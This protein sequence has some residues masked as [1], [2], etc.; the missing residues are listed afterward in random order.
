M[1]QLKE[2]KLK[3]YM[4]Y[5]RLAGSTEGACLVFAN[6]R[7]EARK[8]AFQCLRCWWGEQEWTDTKVQWLKNE[9][10]LYKQANVEKL[11]KNIPHV[12]ESP[13]AC[14]KCELWG[15]ELNENGICENCMEEEE[16][17]NI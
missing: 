5:S 15:A 17:E 12:I 16:I 11:E 8:V 14:K 7:K 9:D 10:Y 6:N 2:H 1:N 4:G 3:L 13:Q